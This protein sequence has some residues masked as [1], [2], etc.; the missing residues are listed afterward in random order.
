MSLAD[1]PYELGTHLHKEWT[2]DYIQREALYR[3][4]DGT[5]G[6]TPEEYDYIKR[7]ARAEGVR[8]DP[9]LAILEAEDEWSPPR[10]PQLADQGYV[11]ITQDMLKEMKASYDA[12]AKVVQDFAV[13]LQV[14]FDDAAQDII[15]VALGFNT[16][17][18]SPPKPNRQERRSA[19]RAPAKKVCPAHGEQMI[20]GRCK[21]C[22]RTK[23]RQRR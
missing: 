3:K 13:A 10:E 19:G 5:F 12:F 15:N 21:V 7:V 16:M 6:P 23:T 11:L 9:A 4:F 1:N 8:E 2:K 20:G 14:A 22:E 17:S 18:I